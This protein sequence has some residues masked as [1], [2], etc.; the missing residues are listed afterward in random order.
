MSSI[1]NTAVPACCI[2]WIAWRD[3]SYWRVFFPERKE[4]IRTWR[5][6]RERVAKWEE[7]GE[8][9]RVVRMDLA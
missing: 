8:K 5:S 4:K 2:S 1:L 6:G 7:S 9:E 3:S